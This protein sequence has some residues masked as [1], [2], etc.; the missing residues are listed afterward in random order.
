VTSLQVP[1]GIFS[2]LGGQLSRNTILTDG[3]EIALKE[4][5]S[6]RAINV[7][8]WFIIYAQNYSGFAID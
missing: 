6:V 1:S 8:K 7:S 3:E 5:I 4:K 2:K